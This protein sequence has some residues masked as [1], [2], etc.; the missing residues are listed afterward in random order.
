MRSASGTTN[1]MA[2]IPRPGSIVSIF[3]ASK[4]F[5]DDIDTQHV[6]TF[7]KGLLNYFSTTARGLR[8]ELSQKRDVKALDK[9]LNDACAAF[10]SGW[11]PG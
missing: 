5:M 2:S 9:Q 10:K 7:E 4:G 6:P 8:E 3:A 1:V 11:K